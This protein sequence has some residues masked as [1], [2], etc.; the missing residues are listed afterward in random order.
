M[1]RYRYCGEQLLPIIL[2]LFISS[3]KDY[4]NIK[5]NM[6]DKYL[7]LDRRSLVHGFTILMYHACNSA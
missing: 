3:V 7:D 4:E 1:L 6:R 2:E 5:G